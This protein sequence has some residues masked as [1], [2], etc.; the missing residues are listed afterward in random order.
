MTAPPLF[1]VCDLSCERGPKQ[2]IFRDLNF[3]LNEGD[4]LVLQGKSGSG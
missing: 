2:R 1:Q 3:T 4:V